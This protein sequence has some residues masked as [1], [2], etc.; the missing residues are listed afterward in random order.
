M[1]DYDTSTLTAEDAKELSEA[2]AQ[3]DEM[4]ENKV[5]DTEE[6]KAANDRF[7][8][9]FN[10][11]TSGDSAK[12]MDGITRALYIITRTISDVLYFIYGDKAF[13]EMAL[14]PILDALFR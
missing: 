2:I 11:I 4:L 10:K 9:I 14:K 1:R 7:Y 13:S 12:T 8:D 5:V 3:V 6:F